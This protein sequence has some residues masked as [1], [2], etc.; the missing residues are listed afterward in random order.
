MTMTTTLCII[1]ALLAVAFLA[2]RF[3]GQSKPANESEVMRVTR[4]SRAATTEA[5]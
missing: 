1:V 3:F 5:E 2:A 4:K